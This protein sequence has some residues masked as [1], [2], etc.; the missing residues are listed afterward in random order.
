M[1]IFVYN[2]TKEDFSDKE[3]N[4]PIYRPSIL[5][6][7]YT[8]IKDKQTKALFVVRTR[9]EAIERY[10]SYFDRMYSGNAPFKFIIDEIYEKYKNGED[11]YLECY[12]KKYPAGQ[13]ESHPDEVRC[14]GDIIKEKLEKR[15]V[16]ERIKE[17]KERRNGNGNKEAQMG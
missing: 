15:L 9:E 14:H 3:N 11:I 12:C 5:S 1:A 7:P 13:G 8:N 17:A 16:K 4:Y 6:N 2:R 10:E